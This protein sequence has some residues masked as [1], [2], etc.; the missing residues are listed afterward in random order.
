MSCLLERV[1]FAHC[2][3]GSCRFR[4]VRL[5][6]CDL[7]N[8]LLRGS[9]AT[10]IEL[11]DCRLTGLKAI[12]CRWRDVLIGNCDACYAQFTNGAV[13]VSELKT[14]QFQDADFRNTALNDS[15]FV[16][17]SLT[18]ADLSGAKLR[19]VDLRGADISEATFRVNDVYG[20]IVSPAQAMELSRL[21]GVLIR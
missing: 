13:I 12:E 8:A 19:N 21:L 4:D 16:Q 18:R 14:S 3:I 20:A 11:V 9:E 7:S 15:I 1:S 2:T 17:S 6:K 10:R 5:E